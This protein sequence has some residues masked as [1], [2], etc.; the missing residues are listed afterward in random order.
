MKTNWNSLSEEA[1]EA[2]AEFYILAKYRAEAANA[3][4]SE[5]C[6]QVGARPG[7]SCRRL[8]KTLFPETVES[9]SCP[10]HIYGPKAFKVLERC[11]LE[12]GWIYQ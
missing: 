6:P 4:L 11:L 2:F 8:C 5:M 1:K 12:D 7:L 10:C 9:I 3:K